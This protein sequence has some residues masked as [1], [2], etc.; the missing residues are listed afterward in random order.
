MSQSPGYNREVGVPWV[1]GASGSQEFPI[2]TM[3]RASELSTTSRSVPSSF[4]AAFKLMT[5]LLSPG[6]H[7]ASAFWQL[8]ETYFPV[9]LP[10]TSHVPE[11][12]S[13]AM[14]A[15]RLNTTQDPGEVENWTQGV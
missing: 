8:I 15:V 3:L 6:T 1:P 2:G 5:I 7:G 14:L 13:I 4:D 10:S 11:C 12:F 9:T